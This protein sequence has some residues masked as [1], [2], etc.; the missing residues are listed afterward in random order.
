MRLRALLDQPVLGLE[1]LTGT[2]SLDRE[3]RWVVTTDLLDP[4]R[5]LSGREL[6]LTGWMWRQ[7]PEDSE[8]F[9]TALIRAGASALAAG[10][11]CGG[12]EGGVIPDDLVQA[13]RRHK[14]PLFR[15]PPNL[16]FASLTEHLARQLSA[17]RAGDIG[18]VLD[19]HSRLVRAVSR[20]GASAA[21]EAL[22]PIL[23]LIAQD[24]GL[25]CWVITSTGRTVAGS[26][27]EPDEDE[28]VRLA[29]SA[30]R[31]A[32]FPETVTTGEA[33]HRSVFV[34][35][36]A[37]RLTDWYLVF[38]GEVKK[39]EPHHQSLATKVAAVLAVERARLEERDEPL[40]RLGEELVR[41]IAESGPEAEITA[42][43]RLLGLDPGG[44]FQAVAA[45]A[46]PAASGS[47][48]PRT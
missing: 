28:R 14:L 4:S 12:E 25:D 22:D 36:G 13:C 40:R 20:T 39:W 16:A 45:A 1:L 33:R 34:I 6:V 10:D 46:G 9:V 11:A 17:Q 8:Q 3:I 15:V 21:G 44:A 37:S 18:S 2:E 35:G 24:L 31:A 19:R 47:G 43:M 27:G 29:H 32:R 48:S 7:R 38:D 41:L 30:V 23:E 42:R 5:Y 26:K